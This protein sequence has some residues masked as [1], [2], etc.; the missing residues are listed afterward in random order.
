MKLFSKTKDRVF[1]FSTDPSL[2][3]GIVGKSLNTTD[4]SKDLDTVRNQEIDLLSSFL[5]I[6]KNNII[7]LN[8]VH[9]DTILEFSAP[10]EG[11]RLFPDSDGMITKTNKL[12]LVIRTADCVP[13]FVFD[14]EQKVLGAAHSG[15]KGCSLNISKMLIRK[16]KTGFKLKNNNLHVYILPSIGPDSYTVNMDVGSLFKNDI[17]T[18]DNKIYLN[19][20]ENISRSI[21]EEG[22]PES[23]IHQSEI[24]TYINNADYF[25]YRRGDEGRNLNFAMINNA[26]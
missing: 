19:L 24:C 2:I 1:N 8:Q 14:V 18:K 25:S 20:W 23:N 21:L 16:M 17:T 6:N 4:Y 3:L 26:N 7:M 5:A 12:C 11:N 9:G 10:L 13:V 22:I 15:W